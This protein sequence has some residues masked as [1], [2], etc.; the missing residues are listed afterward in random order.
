MLNRTPLR[1]N[2]MLITACV[3]LAAALLSAGFVAWALTPLGPSP[4]ALE[5][6]KSDSEVGV[7]EAPYGWVFAA[8][9][10][11]PVT[12]FILYPGGRVDPRSYAP[13]AR[14]LAMHGHAVIVVPM[15]L[16][17]A[18]LSPDRAADVI[19]AN[20]SI[21][22]WT[23]GGHS[24]GGTM[25][26]AYA[27]K[28]PKSIDALALLASYPA[29]STDLSSSDISVISL[30]GT[31]DGVLSAESFKQAVPRLPDSTEFVPIE[32]GNHAQFGSYGSQ[33]GDNRA[34]VDA[35]TQMESAVDA[36]AT[37]MRPLRLRVR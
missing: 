26:A 22:S 5:A 19:A 37:M 14:D 31:R 4:E 1:R 24:L 17:L 21:R 28:A 6:L 18:V 7:T 35:Q 15:R 25:A 11:D 3:V 27:Q 23:I 36:V 2:L 8:T 30:Y 9:D 34:E 32:G 12:G 29:K 16:N 33:P 20:P 10:D 13:F